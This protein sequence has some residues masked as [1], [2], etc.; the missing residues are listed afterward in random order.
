[1]NT[2]NRFALG[3]VLVSAALSSGL[4]FADGRVLTG[5]YTL[6][7]ACQISAGFFGN[8]VL[9]QGQI[10]VTEKV[11]VV[12]D[13]AGRTEFPGIIFQSDADFRPVLSLA[14]GKVAFFQFGPEPVQ[15]GKYADNGAKFV[16][17]YTSAGA[18]S[19]DGEVVIEKTSRGLT[20]SSVD[21]ASGKVTALC[22]LSSTR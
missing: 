15:E 17:Q 16:E 7:D 2:K 10:I 14:I 3:A 12:S 13:D 22:S 21:P 19:A 4:S 6:A 11:P 20:V 5:A 9:P 18:S 1:M 8:R